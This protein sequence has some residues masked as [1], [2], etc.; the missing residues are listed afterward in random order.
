MSHLAVAPRSSTSR[1]CLVMAEFAAEHPDCSH[2]SRNFFP[3][4]KLQTV[5][6]IGAL[7]SLVRISAYLVTAR[8]RRRAISNPALQVLSLILRRVSAKFRHYVSTTPIPTV[9]LT[10]SSMGICSL[11]LVSSNSSTPRHA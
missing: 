1:L 7:F 11:T 10:L 8:C 6:A 2:W 3:Q 5:Q 4:E 9:L